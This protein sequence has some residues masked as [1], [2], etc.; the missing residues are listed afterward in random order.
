MKQQKHK[1]LI[2]KIIIDYNKFSPKPKPLIKTNMIDDKNS[3]PKPL[4]KNNMIDNIYG[5][6]KPKPLMKNN[7]IDIKFINKNSTPKPKHNKKNQK[8]E[9]NSIKRKSVEPK[10]RFANITILDNNG[11]PTHYDNN[12]RPI[13]TRNDNHRT[14]NYNFMNRR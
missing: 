11:V 13:P 10:P 3:T 12:G 8:H 14:T 4:I 9:D 7:L 2:K 1:L 6:P 5:S